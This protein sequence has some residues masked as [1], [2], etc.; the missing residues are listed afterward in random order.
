MSLTGT[1]FAFSFQV[2]KTKQM[3]SML[4][5]LLAVFLACTALLLLFCLMRLR[6]THSADRAIGDDLPL[7]ASWKRPYRRPYLH[8]ARN[9]SNEEE[10]PYNS[11]SNNHLLMTPVSTPGGEHSPHGGGDSFSGLTPRRSHSSRDRICPNSILQENVPEDSEYEPDAPYYA[12]ANLRSVDSHGGVSHCLGPSDRSTSNRSRNVSPSRSRIV[13]RFLPGDIFESG[14]HDRT[15]DRVSIVREG[16]SH[17]NSHL[18]SQHNS[19]HMRHT[20]HGMNMTDCESYYSEGEEG[21]TVHANAWQF[22]SEG[23]AGSTRQGYRTWTDGQR[24]H[25]IGVASC[26][27]DRLLARDIAKRPMH[28]AVMNSTKPSSGR[29]SV[30][31]AHSVRST[32]MPHKMW[33]MHDSGSILS[34]GS[35]SVAP[36]AL[37]LDSSRLSQPQRPQQVE[38]PQHA[39]QP[40]MHASR[41]GTSSTSSRQQAADPVPGQQR[42]S[43][44][45][46]TSARCSP[47]GTLQAEHSTVSSTKKSSLSLSRRESRRERSRSRLLLGT[48]VCW[49]CDYLMHESHHA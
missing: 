35:I 19:P 17:S 12:N 13:Q 7:V 25:S 23:T 28:T 46:T 11:D 34:V 29:E 41:S 5:G 4:S 27:L 44:V 20:I 40:S 21:D 37:Q 43:E 47:H 3:Y 10:N 39:Q 16:F 48:G 26:G 30:H 36:G 18:N 9:H 31:S 38:L 14:G 45:A 33:A 2:V 15:L 42:A 24:L 8:R 49:L 22:N 32:P 6:S 1:C